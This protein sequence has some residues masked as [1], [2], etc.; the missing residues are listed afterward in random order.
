MMPCALA[1]YAKRFDAVKD[2]T[3]SIKESL[4]GREYHAE[5]ARGGRIVQRD[6]VCISSFSQIP[7]RG[8]ESETSCSLTVRVFTARSCSDSRAIRLIV[9]EK[10]RSHGRRPGVG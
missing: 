7:H 9:E 8:V 6:P 3:D 4:V 10:Q 1:S 5:F 2:V